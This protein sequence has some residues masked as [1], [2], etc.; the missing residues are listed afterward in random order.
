MQSQ[1]K[2]DRNEPAIFFY[3]CKLSLG[4]REEAQSGGTCHILTPSRL[5]ETTI[6]LQLYPTVFVFECIRDIFEEDLDLGF[7][8]TVPSF[9]DIGLDRKLEATDP[10]FGRTLEEDETCPAPAD[11]PQNHAVSFAIA[12][13]IEGEILSTSNVPIK[14]QKN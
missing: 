3:Y 4:D 5:N 8:L 6:V 11:N 10:V 14:L 2:S 9:D 1:L 13:M 7:D 12:P